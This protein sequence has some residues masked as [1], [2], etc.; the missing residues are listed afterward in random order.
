MSHVSRSRKRW[1]FAHKFLLIP[2]RWQL[3]EYALGQGSCFG[4]TSSEEGPRAQKRNHQKAIPCFFMRILEVGDVSWKLPAIWN[5]V[6][7]Q[8]CVLWPLPLRWSI[9][10]CLEACSNTESVLK[11]DEI[12]CPVRQAVRTYE[13]NNSKASKCPWNW[14]DSLGTSLSKLIWAIR[15]F[16]RHSQ[17]SQA[18]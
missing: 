18:A 7:G 3:K 11:E 13:V 8:A 9:P 4:R 10:F 15:I 17:T 2:F 1:V 14:P 16:E 12:S 6:S 5:K